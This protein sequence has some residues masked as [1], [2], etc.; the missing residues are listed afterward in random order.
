MSL[1][2]KNNKGLILSTLKFITS[3]RMYRAIE[4]L[5]SPCCT[6][7][8]S[9]ISAICGTGS[10]V[11]VTITLDKSMSLLGIGDAEIYFNGAK[12]SA[13]TSYLDGVTIKFTNIV[14]AAG[15]YTDAFITLK[16]PTNSDETMGVYLKSNA[17][18]VTI[19]SCP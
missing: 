14:V 11:T 13:S 15:A 8:I 3:K 18:S 4:L 17:V 12:I 7:V 2:N 6:P 1:L 5:V 10:T 19:P 9:V 16:L